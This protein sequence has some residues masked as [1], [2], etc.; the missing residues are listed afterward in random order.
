MQKLKKIDS[1]IREAMRVN[2]IDGCRSLI[3]S[4]FYDLL[5]RSLLKP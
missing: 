5:T 1:F 2:G 4:Y 3:I